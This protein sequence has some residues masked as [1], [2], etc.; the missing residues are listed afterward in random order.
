MGWIFLLLGAG[1]RPSQGSTSVFCYYYYLC[2]LCS[3]FPAQ[4]QSINLVA[5]PD[6]IQENFVVLKQLTEAIKLRQD[7]SVVTVLDVAPSQG[8]ASVFCYYYTWKFQ[9][10]L[11]LLQNGG[12]GEA[13]YTQGQLI[14]SKIQSV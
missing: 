3:K 6:Q 14:H 12:G 2:F 4:L 1:R 8:S 13:T 5:K 11:F 10:W 7:L 9:K